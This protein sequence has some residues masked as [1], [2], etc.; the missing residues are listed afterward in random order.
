MNLCSNIHDEVC[1]EGRNCPA[2]EMRDNLQGTIDDLKKDNRSLEDEIND[3]T[4]K[5]QVTNDEKGENHE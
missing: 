4:E 2:C 5:I 3:F 1:Y